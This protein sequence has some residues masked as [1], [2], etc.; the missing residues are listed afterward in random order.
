MRSRR[1]S[2]KLADGNAPQASSSSGYPPR[3]QE[4]GMHG[5]SLCNKEKAELGSRATEPCATLSFLGRASSAIR[6]SLALMRAR[7]IFLSSE[8]VSNVMSRL[9]CWQFVW[10]PSRIFCARSRNTCEH[11]VHLI[12]TFSSIIKCPYAHLHYSAFHSLTPS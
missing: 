8:L 1:G 6:T 2:A 3:L 12:F 7:R 5:E 4:R 11:F 9:Q 10:N